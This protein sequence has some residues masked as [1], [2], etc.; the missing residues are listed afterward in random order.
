MRTTIARLVMVCLLSSVSAAAAA[1][2]S[3]YPAPRFP[4]YVRLPTNIEDI[5]LYARGALRSPEIRAL[6]SRYGNLNDTDK[7]RWKTRGDVIGNGI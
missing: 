2:V 6:T 7:D 4:S 5:M 1:E 3:K